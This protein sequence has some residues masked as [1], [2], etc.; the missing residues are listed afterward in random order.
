MAAPD[1]LQRRER[2]L[3]P[4]YRL[5]YDQPVHLVRGEGAWLFGADGKR[6]LDCYNN[7]ASVGHCHPHVVAALSSQAATLNTHTRYLHEKIVSYAERLGAT[8]PGELSVCM[9]V[10]TGTEANDLAVR[11]A[12]AVTGH[13]GVIVTEDAYHGNSTTVYRLSTEEYPAAERPD[14]LEAVEAPCTYRGR[15]QGPGPEAARQFAGLLDD[16][17]G[18]LAARGHGTAMFLTDNIYSSNGVLTPDPAYLQEA[19]RRVR[20][21]GGLAVADEVQSGL[22]RL[23]DHY[24]GFEDSGVV[25]DIV[26]MGKPLGDGHPLAAVV[27]TPEI[28]GRFASKYDYFNTFGGNPVSAAVGSAVLDVIEQEGILRNVHATGAGL[29]AGLRA[30]MARYGQ[31][32]DVRGKGLFYGVEIVSDRATREAA[33]AEAARVR[34]HLRENGILLGTSGPRNNVIKIRPPLVFN[35]EHAALL[36]AGLDSALAAA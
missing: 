33:P 19:Y 30:L 21:A 36:L 26:T 12:R 7:V 10:C 5:F 29:G 14:W 18:R 28:A 9:F 25:P 16:A 22:C 32:G 4:A 34:E 24:W 1:L 2:A 3:G 15:F 8:L 31:V 17:T 35:R 20:A 6:Y 27:T 23:G 13:E 11:I